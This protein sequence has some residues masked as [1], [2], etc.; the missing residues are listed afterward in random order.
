VS[1][2]PSTGLW[3]PPQ[4][5]GPDTAKVIITF[6][7]QGNAS[8]YSSSSASNSSLPS[9]P[10][11]YAFD[12]EMQIDHEQR[13]QSTE[14]PTQTGA[15]ISDHAF[16]MPARLVLD[17]GVSD[18]MAQ[19]PTSSWAGAASK[20]VAAYQTML[21]LQLS[22]IPL[23]ITTR[24]RTYQNMIIEGLAPVET[25]KTIASLRMRVEFRQIFVADITQTPTS[26]RPQDTQV[27]N[28]GNVNPQPPSAA[29][30]QQNNVTGVTDA[31]AVPS[32]A[33]GAGNYSSVNTDNL[34]AL[35]TPK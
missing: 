24:L 13:L 31:P 29:V 23:E 18:V 22:R 17:V 1:A 7:G 35:P 10:T 32:A 27:T 4:W 5:I 8:Q 33:I 28:R 2:T 20:S 14:H 3:R 12:A 15:S 21:A 11:L 26:A 34:P 30:I 6:P 19:Y 9:G 25:H 16:V